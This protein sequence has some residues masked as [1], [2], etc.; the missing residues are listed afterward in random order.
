MML[1]KNDI[2]SS[3]LGAA[4][5]GRFLINIGRPQRFGTQYR[6]EDEGPLRLYEVGE[7]ASDESRRVMAVPS[8]RKGAGGESAATGRAGGLMKGPRGAPR[9]TKV[10][11]VRHCVPLHPPPPLLL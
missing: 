9:G 5:E 1:G 4:A 2:E 8:L 10:N 11:V 6:S 3:H 7:G